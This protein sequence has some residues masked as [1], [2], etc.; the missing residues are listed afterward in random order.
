M[1]DTNMR[2]EYTNTLLLM[3][4]CSSDALTRRWIEA[5]DPVYAQADHVL[6]KVI[7]CANQ[8]LRG[9]LSPFAALSSIV[10]MAAPLYPVVSTAA[11]SEVDMLQ[12]AQEFE[13]LFRRLSAQA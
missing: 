5:Q 6:R 9:E 1:S 11:S 3:H 7:Q 8:A 12:A 2:S 10:E 4:P 13:Q